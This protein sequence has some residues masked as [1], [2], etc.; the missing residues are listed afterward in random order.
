LEKI[1]KKEQP[2]HPNRRLFG[3]E[4]LREDAIIVGG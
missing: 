4:L 2:M 3:N 1:R